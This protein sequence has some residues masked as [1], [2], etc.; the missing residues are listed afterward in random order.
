MMAYGPIVPILR[1]FD[2]GRTIAFYTDYLGG[3]I[4][5]EH[6]FE[7]DLPLYMQVSLGACRIHLSEHY[8]DCSPGAAIRI[9]VADIAALHAGLTA[10][11]AAFSRP[12][13][14]RMPWGDDEVTVLDPAGNRLVFYEVRPADA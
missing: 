10:K 6:R 11:A 2:I 3:T 9:E 5:W 14:A 13:L 1:M 4:D 12:G 8:G 7:P